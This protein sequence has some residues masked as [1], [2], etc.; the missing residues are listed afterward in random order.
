MMGR[1]CPISLKGLN[2]ESMKP[3]DYKANIQRFCEN[4]SI[5]ERADNEW[6]FGRITYH[7]MTSVIRHDSW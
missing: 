7:S 1:I 4:N 3:K 6:G 2:E 5:I